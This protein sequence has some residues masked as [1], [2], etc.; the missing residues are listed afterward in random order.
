MR[1]RAA[2]AVALILQSSIAMA[3]DV[4]EP[5]SIRKQMHLMAPQAM[6]ELVGASL[7]HLGTRLTL[8]PPQVEPAE[9]AA[10]IVHFCGGLGAE[11]SDMVAVTRRISRAEFR[12]CVENGVTDVVEIAI[13]YDAAVLVTKAEVPPMLLTSEQ[14]FRALARDLPSNNGFVPN[15]AKTW[16]DVDRTL[17]SLDIRVVTTGRGTAAR[18]LLEDKVLQAGCR[19]LPEIRAIYAAD[20]RVARCVTPRGDGRLVEVATPEA[21]LALLDASPPGAVAVIPQQQA[22]MTGQ[23]YQRISVDGM[24]PSGESIRSREYPLSRRLYYY[25]KVGHM[26]DRKGYGVASNL[27]E[28]MDDAVGEAAVGPDGY[29]TA[30]GLVPLE[31]GER[32]RQRRAAAALVPM[33]R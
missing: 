8:A 13:G 25:F 20:S 28:L 14:I 27:R 15:V 5:F 23:R 18:S 11:H 3:A 16:N 30:A 22:E 6:A 21:A 26:R 2:F 33:E 7:T 31:E 19:N 1:C 17:P 32:T 24:L 4:S 12:R 10:A 9:T 29:F